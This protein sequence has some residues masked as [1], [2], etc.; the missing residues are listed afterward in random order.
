MLTFSRA[1]S[2]QTSLG[3]EL[4]HQDDPVAGEGLAHDAPLG[5]PV[6]EG[7]HREE[8]ER[9]TGGRPFSTICSGRSMRVA[10]HGVDAAAEGEE[11]VLVAPDHALGHA[12]GPA[13]VEDVDVVARAGGEVALG[14]GGG[15]G[16]LEVDGVVGRVRAP[17]CRRR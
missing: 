2:D 17:G 15:Q 6:H 16:L 8:G 5:G 3:I 9:P 10:G 4:G 7:G 12:G 14:G 1:T 11:D 13:G